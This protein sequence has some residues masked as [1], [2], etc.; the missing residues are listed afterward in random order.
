MRGLVLFSLLLFALAMA[1][2]LAAIPQAKPTP[3]TPA[4]GETKVNPKDGLTYVWIPPGTFQMG[5]SP[6]DSECGGDD[7]PEKPAHT[8]TITK[9]FWMGQTEVTQA[10][11]QRVTKEN[12]SHFHGDRLPVEDVMWAEA[13]NYCTA[14]GMQLP[15]EAQWEYAARAGSSASRYGALDAIA[16][17]S[18]TSGSQTHEVAQKQPNA[19]KLHDM[20]GNVSEWTGD[21]YDDNYYR[22][23]PSQ[24]P[25]GP[26]AGEFG[27]LRGG[28]WNDKAGWARV[29]SRAGGEPEYR[30]DGWV[31]FRCAG[32]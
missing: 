3:K 27:V 30:G 25:R 4:P 17:Y 24:D 1:I 29:S 6:G 23:S 2:S 10:A 13:D 14:V 32:E 8:V 20:L 31:G 18:S 11:Y 12:P 16:W 21:W 28:S 5:C 15:A 26:S 19:W 7:S 22:H 9:G